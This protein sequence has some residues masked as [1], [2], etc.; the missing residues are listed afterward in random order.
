[1]SFSKDVLGLIYIEL[2]FKR[3]TNSFKLVCREWL[4]AANKFRCEYEEKW[5]N[6]CSA[7]HLSGCNESGYLECQVC[8]TNGLCVK[9]GYIKCIKCARRLCP[10]CS[11]VVCAICIECSDGK[12][13]ADR[14]WCNTCEQI[15]SLFVKGADLCFLQHEYHY[16]DSSW[17][18]RFVNVAR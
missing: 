9:D 15:T 11:G 3:D 14:V 10:D 1:M 4:A 7:L 16:I 18:I 6:S 17:K 2:K 12:L 5:R 8:N 13:A